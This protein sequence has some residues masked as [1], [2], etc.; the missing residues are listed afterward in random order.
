MNKPIIRITVQG[1]LIQEI[2]F[3]SGELK[4]GEKPEIQV[5][6]FDTDGGGRNA[7]NQ[8][9]EDF[10]YSD[11]THLMLDV[12]VESMNFV[13]LNEEDEIDED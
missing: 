3:V 6:D 11:W 1:G 2:D 7:K 4:N 12:P 9:G 13:H 5:W 8:E 10:I